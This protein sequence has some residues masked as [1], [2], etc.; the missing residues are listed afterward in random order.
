MIKHTK[1]AMSSTKIVIWQI[2]NGRKI[3][4][5]DSSQGFPWFIP[6]LAFFVLNVNFW[7]ENIYNIWQP[8]FGKE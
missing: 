4:Q 1:T 2:S 5:N 7:F 8:C 6:K 3:L